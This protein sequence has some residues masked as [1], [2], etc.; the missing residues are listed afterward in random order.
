MPFIVEHDDEKTE[1]PD[2]SLLIFIDETGQEDFADPGAPFFGFGGCLSPVPLYASTID[3]PWQG[4]EELFPDELLPLHATDL[5]REHLTDERIKAISTFFRNGQFGR[6]AAIASKETLNESDDNIYH[7]MARVLYERIL[8][9]TS[10]M[11]FNTQQIIM[12][13]EHSE[14]TDHLMGDYFRRY[15]FGGS[16]IEKIPTFYATQTKKDELA[17]GLKVADFIAHTA[18]AQVRANLK[19]QM[20]SRKDFKDVFQTKNPNL[21]SFLQVTKINN[22]ETGSK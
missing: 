10:H 11:R 17:A 12:I 5:R 14:R 15:H 18:G 9:I 1:F 6:F 21:S 2:E 20:Y 4:I 7:L 16:K 19:G 3:Q 13:F 8:A 22:K